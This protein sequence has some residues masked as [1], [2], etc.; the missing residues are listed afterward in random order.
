MVVA[1]RETREAIQ[2]IR[3][4]QQLP[5]RNSPS[6]LYSTGNEAAVTTWDS[7]ISFKR[8]GRFWASSPSSKAIAIAAGTTRMAVAGVGNRVDLF[9]DHCRVQTVRI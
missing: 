1:R 6:V 3:Q 9:V 7:S 2:A 4:Q 5:Q 8:T